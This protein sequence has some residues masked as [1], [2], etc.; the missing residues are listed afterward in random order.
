MYCPFSVNNCIKKAGTNQLL[1]SICGAIIRQPALKKNQNPTASP[2]EH[3]SC[4]AERES[5]AALAWDVVGEER[6]ESPESVITRVVSGQKRVNIGVCNQS[7]Q[8]K[9]YLTKGFC[10]RDLDGSQDR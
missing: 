5:L 6:K 1:L 2:R 8:C 7:P 4:S 9:D 10:L 3:R